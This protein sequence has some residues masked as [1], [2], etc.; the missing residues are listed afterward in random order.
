MTTTLGEDEST[1]LAEDESTVLAEDES[2]VLAED[3]FTVSNWA[4]LA[5]QGQLV[6]AMMV[7]PPG[8]GEFPADCLQRDDG[9]LRTSPPPGR[10][11]RALVGP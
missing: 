8:F 6:P 1:V 10:N 4:L 2:T 3:D 7:L 5:F 9:V 11:H